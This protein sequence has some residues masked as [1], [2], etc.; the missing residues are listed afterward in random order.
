[1]ILYRR[2]ILLFCTLSLATAGCERGMGERES[3]DLEVTTEQP[4]NEPEPTPQHD[5]GSDRTDSLTLPDRYR[6]LAEAAGDLDGDERPERVVVAETGRVGEDG[7][8][9]EV[10]VYRRQKGEWTLWTKASGP[11]MPSGSGGVWGD[12][13]SSVDVERGAI[14]IHHYGGSNHRWSYTHRFRYQEDAFELIGA[15]SEYGVNGLEWTIFDYNLSTGR[16]TLSRLQFDE[17][18]EESGTPETTRLELKPTSLPSMQRFAPGE[19]GVEIAGGEI[20]Y[21]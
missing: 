19:T 17:N 9:R 20:V 21:Y 12:P 16:A 14:V 15:T 18:G 11:V 6:P 5:P 1:M 3:P 8:E 10:L 13:F 7:R 4:Q 2:T